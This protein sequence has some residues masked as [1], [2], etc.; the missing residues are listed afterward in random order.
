MSEQSSD[1]DRQQ[2]ELADKPLNWEVSSEEIKG[3]SHE[4]LREE[5]ILANEKIR[6]LYEVVMLEVQS[7]R[8]SQPVSAEDRD[9]ILNPEQIK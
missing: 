2:A 9:H 6:R 4:E 1:P 7:Q 8:S 3:M 5:V